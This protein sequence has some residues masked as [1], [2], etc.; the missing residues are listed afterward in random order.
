MTSTPA[1]DTQTPRCDYRVY[2][3]RKP[4]CADAKLVRAVPIRVLRRPYGFRSEC[5]EVFVCR[6]DTEPYAEAKR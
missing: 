1:D 3:L 5:S 6:H 2:W 4:H